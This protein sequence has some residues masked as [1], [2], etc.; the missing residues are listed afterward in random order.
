[1]EN[2]GSLPLDPIDRITKVERAKEEDKRYGEQLQHLGSSI[3]EA[4]KMEVM[5]RF[6]E[7]N[8]GNPL[9]SKISDV[10]KSANSGQIDVGNLSIGYE[11]LLKEYESDPEGLKAL[12]KDES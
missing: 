2:M 9:A 1:M 7:K 3:N 11:R 4:A 10:L 6:V 8:P 5:L 12:M